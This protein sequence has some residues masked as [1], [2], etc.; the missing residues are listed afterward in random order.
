MGIVCPGEG[1][2][3]LTFAFNT[4]DPHLPHYPGS[5]R[6][7]RPENKGKDPTLQSCTTAGGG[8]RVSKKHPRAR[9]SEQ[10]SGPGTAHFLCKPQAGP[11]G[12]RVTVEESPAA[13][14][15]F[16]GGLEG[17]HW[18]WVRAER[19]GEDVQAERT[20]PTLFRNKRPKA[21]FFV[22]LF[23]PLREK[24][25]QPRG[26]VGSKVLD[27]RGSDLPRPGVGWVRVGWGGGVLR[28]AAFGSGAGGRYLPGHSFL[29]TSPIPPATFD[30]ASRA[31]GELSRGQGGDAKV[32]RGAAQPPS[33]RRARGP[34]REVRRPRRAQPPPALLPVA[35]ARARFISATTYCSLSQGH[36]VYS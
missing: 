12:N 20:P 13:R 32:S 19:V 5:L 30:L 14:A 7:P 11:S 36:G 35:P 4:T 17:S 16:G 2:G 18:R 24:P 25:E 26:R 8:E 15:G 22:A 6:F 10:G 1:A 23:W 21:P 33:R 3:C 34:T 27:P 31:H 28:G 29:L 9:V